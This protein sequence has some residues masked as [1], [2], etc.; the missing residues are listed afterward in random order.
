VR[1]TA[2]ASRSIGVFAVPLL[3]AGMIAAISP[4]PAAA[5]GP[6]AAPA[7]S[8]T[9]GGELVG[10]AAT[11]ARNAWAVGY[12]GS[13]YSRSEPLIARWNGTSWKRVPSPVPGGSALSSLNGVAATSARSAWAAACS[14]KLMPIPEARPWPRRAFSALYAADGSADRACPVMTPR[15]IAVHA[16]K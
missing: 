9:V 14:R 13:V 1:T 11:S 16:E 12:T 6:T 10:L 5:A 2:A 3:A 4:L 15:R 7:S 8:F